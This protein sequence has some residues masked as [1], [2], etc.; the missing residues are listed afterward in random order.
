MN[1]RDKNVRNEI[2][3][4]V[5]RIEGDPD[6]FGGRLVVEMLQTCLKLIG[7]GHDTGQLKLMNAALKEMRYAYQVFNQYLGHRK[8]SIFGSAGRS[9]EPSCTVRS[10]E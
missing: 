4:L 10:S 8:I 7:D 9:P 3:D 6:S 5:R 2:Q 1:P